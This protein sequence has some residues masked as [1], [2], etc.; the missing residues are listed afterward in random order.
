MCMKINVNDGVHTRVSAFV[1]A[2]VRACVLCL[3]YV[4]GIIDPG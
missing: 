1:R 3:Q 4:I 2:C